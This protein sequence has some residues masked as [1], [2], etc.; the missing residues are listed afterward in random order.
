MKTSYGFCQDQYCD[1]DEQAYLIEGL[2][3][4]CYEANEDEES[5]REANR[6]DMYD[7]DFGQVPYGTMYR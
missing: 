4:S 7:D 2:C 1:F 6:F 5:F 3:T